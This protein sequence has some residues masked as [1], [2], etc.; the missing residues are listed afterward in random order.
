MIIQKYLETRIDLFDP[1]DILNPNLNEVCMKHLSNRFEG[2]CYM[3][4]LIIKII[5]IIKHS[6]RYMSN[7]LYG[8]AYIHVSFEVDGIIYN[9]GEIITGC[10]IVKIESDGRIHAK[11][12]YAGLQ[13]RQD[14]SLINIYKEGFITPFITKRVLYNPAQSSISVEALPFTPVYPIHIIYKITKP[15]DNTE[16]EKILY[17]FEQLSIILKETELVKKK[18]IKSYEFFEKLLYPYKKYVNFKEKGLKKINFDKKLMEITKGYLINPRESKYN[19]ME[20]FGSDKNYEK[21]DIKIEEKPLV[22]ILEIFIRN[23]ILHYKTL[24]EFVESYST[25][26]QVKKYKDVWKL[27]DILKR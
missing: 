12:K 22:F 6:Q 5:R 21:S 3:S 10:N 16:R 8:N 7:D 17:L 9:K 18:S 4:C 19:D 2:K 23:F 25:I 24:L 14:E 13:I 20:I 1:L 26:E 15:L 27:Y 11:S